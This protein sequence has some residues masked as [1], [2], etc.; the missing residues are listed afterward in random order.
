M[1]QFILLSFLVDVQKYNFYSCSCFGYIAVVLY[2]NKV[3][4]KTDILVCLIH[5]RREKEHEGLLPHNWYS[6]S[7][8]NTQTCIRSV[9][10]NTVY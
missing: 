9:P 3:I 4:S 7:Q 2:R 1:F 6:N 8:K 10:N 5:F